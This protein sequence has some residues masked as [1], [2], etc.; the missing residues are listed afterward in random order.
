MVPMSQLYRGTIHRRSTNEPG[1]DVAHA[2]TALGGDRASRST[3]AVDWRHPP[4]A[5]AASRLAGGI[6][7][8]RQP[9]GGARPSHVAV[10]VVTSLRQRRRHRS[11]ATTVAVGITFVALR[12]WSATLR[13]IRQRSATFHSIRQRWLPV[14]LESGRSDMCGIFSRFSSGHFAILL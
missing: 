4:P 2:T 9:S 8:L 1:H 10:F 3:A 12:Q 6:A 5:A 14:D 7:S 13:S 11:A